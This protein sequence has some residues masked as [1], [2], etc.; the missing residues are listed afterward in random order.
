MRRREE[1]RCRDAVLLGLQPARGDHA[2]PVARRQPGEA[3]LGPRRHEVVADG[4]LVVEE[5]AGRND[6]DGVAAAVLG[7]G[8]APA[9]AVEA[10]DRVGAAGF[11]VAAEHVALPPIH[12]APNVASR[13]GPRLEWRG[14]PRRCRSPVATT[15]RTGHGNRLTQNLSAGSNTWGSAVD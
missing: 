4:P 12:H 8:R 14:V 10:G 15:T 13:L 2:P 6:A 1:H 3:P 7:A 5:L 9:V 11:E